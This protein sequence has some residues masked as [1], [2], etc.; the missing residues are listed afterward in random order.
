MPFDPDEPWTCATAIDACNVVVSTLQSVGVLEQ[1][2]YP[3]VVSD[4]VIL[5][6]QPCR[7][8]GSNPRRCRGWQMSLL[9]QNA[10]RIRGRAG[11]RDVFVLI[12]GSNDRRHENGTTAGVHVSGGSMAMTVFDDEGTILTRQHSDIANL[13]QWGPVGH[14]QLGG[15]P[16]VGARPPVEWLDQPRWPL[17]PMDIVLLAELTLYSFAP[18]SWALVHNQPV[19]QQQVQR[20]E[21]LAYALWVEKLQTYWNQRGRGS[22]WL[23]EQCN[24]T[25]PWPR[26]VP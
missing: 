12:E 5:R 1:G 8:R 19:W 26:A 24:V 23:T 6:C 15:L 4:G 9:P 7:A 25:T 14:L 3:D 13:G 11:A 16:S 20:S 2:P 17:P 21:S 18:E 22:T 10:L